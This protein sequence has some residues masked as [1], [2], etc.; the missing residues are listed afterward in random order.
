[1]SEKYTGQAQDRRYNGVDV[2]ITYNV[3]RCIHA[4]HCVNQLAPVFDKQKRPWINPDAVAAGDIATIIGDCPSGALHYE[5]KD[6]G[7]VEAIPQRNI[8]TLWQD[9]PLQFSG[10]LI[11]NGA[12][13]AI[14]SETRATLC[15]C[16]ASNNKPFCDN[17]HKDIGFSA[18]V[19]DSQSIATDMLETGGSL[20]IT[21]LPDG[22][23]QVEGNLE[24]HDQVGNILYAG[25]KTALCRCGGSSNKPFCDGTHTFNQ[26]KAE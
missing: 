10:D 6:G 14:M 19:L 1:M 13:V 3:K 18:E 8:I 5:H 11:M 9:G 23:L 4:E 2:D 12:T 17:S 25:T 16:G 7:A 22:P 26:F 15:R 21:A 24:I 20:T